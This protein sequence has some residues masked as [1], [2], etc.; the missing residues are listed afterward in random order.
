MHPMKSARFDPPGNNGDFAT[1]QNLADQ[2]SGWL[3]NEFDVG[4]ASV[5]AFLAA[6]G[7]GACQFIP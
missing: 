7:G 5:T 1:D 4:V 3:S 2:Y 6:Q